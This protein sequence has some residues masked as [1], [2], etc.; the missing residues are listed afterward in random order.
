MQS[1]TLPSRVLFREI[2]VDITMDEALDAV[3]KVSSASAGGQFDYDDFERF[4]STLFCSQIP[5][6]QECCFVR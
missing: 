4:C 3:S 5:C 6:L 2:G 1:D